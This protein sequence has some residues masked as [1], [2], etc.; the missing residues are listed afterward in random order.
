METT[1][2]NTGRQ[3]EVDVAKV[4]A[5]LYMVVIHVYEEMSFVNYFG[6]M[7]DSLFRGVLEF[8]GG[9][10]AA[11]VFMFAM[12]LGMVYTAKNSPREFALRGMRLLL[13]SYLLNLVRYTIPYLISKEE[14]G[15]YWSL[16]DTI[17]VVDILQLAGM[18]FLLVALL[19]KCRVNRYGIVAVALLLQGVGTLL[20]HSFH[21][22][23]EAAQYAM[24][25]LFRTNGYVVFPLSLWFVYPAF[26]Y[27]F[28]EYLQTVEDKRTMY[29]RLA[30]VS[31]AVLFAASVAMKQAGINIMNNFA[32]F[33]DIYYVQNFSTTVWTLSVIGLQL[34]VCYRISLLLKGRVADGVVSISK[35]LKTI[36]IVQWIII[37]YAM[38]AIEILGAPRV[39]VWAIVPCGVLIAA[40]STFVSK[41]I[42]LKF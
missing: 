41:Y 4:L 34:F 8:A 35:R 19:K 24:G 38:F 13:V 1:K 15:G 5:I 23:P 2:V 33:H 30:I 14:P 3:L 42:K 32:L 7:P 36:Y 20:L 9:P 29:N 17:G 31:L 10:L 12:G 26:G 21:G 18:S 25:L 27:F 39:P 22:W 11:P 6:K 28:G 40:V 37:A 16:V